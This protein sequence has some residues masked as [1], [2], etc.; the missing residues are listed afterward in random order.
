MLFSSN[1]FLFAFLPVVLLLYYVSPRRLRNPVLL[2][3]SLVFYGWG[4]PVYL[5]LMIATILLNYG[6]GLW[7]HKKQTAGENG[8][9]PLVLGVVANLVILGFFKY[10][11]FFVRQLQAIAP[12]LSGIK[13]PEISLPIGIS[14]Y[15]FQSMSYV[16]DVYRSDAPVQKNPL[17]F[18]T[19]V[20]L[21]PQLIAGPIVRYQDV[22]EQMEVR[23]ENVH[24]FASGVQLFV[25]GLGKKVL[26]ANPMGNFWNLLQTEGG[27]LTAWVGILAYSL[28][29]YF[30]FSG[31]S[32]MARG[33]GRMF[34]F[35][36]LENFNYPYISASVTEFWRRWHISLSTWFRE[37]VYIPLGG[38]RKGLPRQILNL[39]IVWGL[40]GFWH[41]A[42]WNFI[43]WGLY[44]AVLLILEKLFLLK[45]LKKAPGIFGH[46]YT[47]FAVLLGWVLF[48]FENLSS[49]FGFFGRLFTPA[50][51]SVHGMNLVLAFTPML[52]ISIFAATPAAKVLVSGRR[53]K[54]VV[55]YG[56]VAVVMVMLLLCVAALASQSYNPFIYFRF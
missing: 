19:Y 32:D 39:L 16:I 9:L 34:G 37:Y 55:R 10:A 17:T 42:S 51:A 20:T 50:A 31:Y 7:I 38:N 44:Y 47:I 21:F 46:L 6:F 28:Q 25:L 24:D 4:E 3:W 29:I 11:G 43:L 8:K 27:T 36:F 30:D 45:L 2:L 18:G 15:V 41:G 5:F 12:F 53:D 33:L 35:E 26:L 48:Y 49:L 22:A 56:A 14:F 13:A 23:R 40:T 54:A 1:V 52:L